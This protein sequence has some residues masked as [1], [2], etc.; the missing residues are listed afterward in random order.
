MIKS[1]SLAH[2]KAGFTREEFSRYWKE[3][4]GP[5]AAKM[6]PGLRKY[7]QNHFITVPGYEYK[8]DGL[9]EMWYD[10]VE[11]FKKSIEFVRSETGKE[12]AQDG[13]KFSELRNGGF[14]W[15]VEEH[16]IKDELT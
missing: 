1:I 10:D 2:R 12:L 8:G 15:I 16:V 13:D 14:F 3:Q 9:V 11:A 4:H 7:V 5:L 6:I